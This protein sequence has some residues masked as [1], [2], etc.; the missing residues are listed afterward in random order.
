VKEIFEAIEENER[1]RI[2]FYKEN[3]FVQ[4]MKHMLIANLWNIEGKERKAIYN[5]GYEYVRMYEGIRST[6]R[7]EFDGTR[8]KIGKNPTVQEWLGDFTYW[9]FEEMIRKPNG[10]NRS[11][12]KRSK[13]I[14]DEFHQIF[15]QI[16]PD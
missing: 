12:K 16:A 10:M 14:Y 7:G 3:G 15:E 9:L 1:K 11:C 13:K 2:K 4:D 5:D 6:I 8:G